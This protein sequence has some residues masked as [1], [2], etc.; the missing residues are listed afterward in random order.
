[1]SPIFCRLGASV[2]DSSTSK[3]AE[4][5]KLWH[6]LIKKSFEET[7]AKKPVSEKEAL[8]LCDAIQNGLI[9]CGRVLE[10]DSCEPMEVYTKRV[11]A[12][13]TTYNVASGQ[14]YNTTDPCPAL[15]RKV[16]RYTLPACKKMMD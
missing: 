15:A 14:I 9:I 3:V 11:R 5:S 1:M 7:K 8:E 2:S 4:E 16:P 6:Q 10:K 12:V 13:H